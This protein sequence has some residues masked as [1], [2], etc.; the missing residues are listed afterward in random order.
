MSIS[1]RESNHGISL[2]LH[3]ISKCFCEMSQIY[4]RP[5]E[6]DRKRNRYVPNMGIS[7][8]TSEIGL[9]SVIQAEPLKDCRFSFMILGRPISFFSVS[10]VGLKYSSALKPSKEVKKGKIKGHQ[11]WIISLF[12]RYGR[13]ISQFCSFFDT[14]YLSESI[15]ART[16]TR[17]SF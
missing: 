1:R 6:L 10:G 13:S 16:A 2:K 12:D 7:S 17:R 3:K 4:T 11:T 14:K 9:F 15:N 8:S 5:N